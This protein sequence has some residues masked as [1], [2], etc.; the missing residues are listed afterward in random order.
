MIPESNI[1][2]ANIY[3]EYYKQYDIS[4]LH[5]SIGD[6]TFTLQFTVKTLFLDDSD[7]VL[8]SPWME[9]LGSIILNVKKKILT[10]S[11]KKKK[12]TF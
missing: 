3:G 2:E 10:L 4:N 6:Y 1:V 12:I 7:I 11:Y 8:G 9:T 5:Q